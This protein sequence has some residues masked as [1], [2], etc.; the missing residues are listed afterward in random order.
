[1]HH[2]VFLVHVMT[3]A[4]YFCY[5][6]VDGER[7]TILGALDAHDH[8]GLHSEADENI[9]SRAA[10]GPEPVRAHRTHII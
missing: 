8:V 5:G 2:G 3:S 1:M 6:L 9:V 7:V 10:A 4:V